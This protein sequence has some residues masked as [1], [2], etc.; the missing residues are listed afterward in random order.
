VVFYILVIAAMNIGLGFG[1][2][3]FL[4]RLCRRAIPG[5]DPWTA[6][7]LPE[8]PIDG[9]LGDQQSQP[10]AADAASADAP[11]SLSTVTTA[12]PAIKPAFE[13]SIDGQPETPDAADPEAAEIK[14]ILDSLKDPTQQYLEARVLD[15]PTNDDRAQPEMNRGSRAAPEERQPAQ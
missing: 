1:A 6:D 3:V 2:A 15:T 7:A 14:N 8:H 13:A 10:A 12:A 9:V 5:D 4:G 11:P